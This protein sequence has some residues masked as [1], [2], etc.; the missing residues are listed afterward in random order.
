MAVG[1]IPKYIEEYPL[2]D[3]APEQFIVIAD[4][5]IKQLEWKI[6]YISNTGII[7]FTGDGFF[8]RCHEVRITIE[9]TIATLKSSSVR[10]EMIDWG[11]NKSTV[12]DFIKTFDELRQT[13]TDDELASKH[14]I[15]K[16]N[17][18]PE[19]NDLLKLP[20][21]GIAEQ[22]TG[23]LSI[24]KPA[25]GY[26]IT[27]ILVN[28]N[29]L[30]F[31]LMAIM[32][33]NI[34][35]PDN[36]SLLNW[37]ANFRPLTLDGQW[38]RLITNI[39]L[40]IGIIH[41]LLNMYALVYIGLLLEPHLGKIRFISAYLLTGL[42]A[43]I[44]SL[45]WHDITI[46]AGASGAIF[47]MYG[48]FL[49]MLTTDLIEKTT[50]K[51]LLTSIGI[52]VA[53]NLIN[54]VKGNID[55]AAHIGGL[56]GGLIIGYCFTPSLKKPDDNPL[57]YSIIGSLTV[58]TIIA[59]SL[60]YRGIPNDIGSYE[61]EMKRFSSMESMALEVYSLPKNT[62][63]SKLLY[64]IKDRGIYYWNEDLKIIDEVKKL[65]LP[66]TLQ[67]QADKLKQ[68]CELRLKSYELLYKTVDE[69]SNQY[70]SQIDDY[71]KQIQNI[72]DELKKS[73]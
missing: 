9:N 35:M 37:G 52:F 40:H 41:L 45:W 15:I 26:L 66:E 53:Y 44:A 69:D 12:K 73:K 19:E 64:E 62:P 8:S 23:F 4:E 13:F 28:L 1:F 25:K 59:C 30:V 6:S 7:A 48:V 27:P 16:E 70:Q 46:S 20:P 50:R 14:L 22:V 57:N 63:K 29:I 71:N 47:G 56:I 32:G 2:N 39:F 65:Q 34:L 17:L 54:G 3:L 55:N 36:E 68:Y 33:I 18:V 49:A 38:W 60:V 31:I 42:T 24:F 43:S 61:K 11:R 10:N 5:A 67:T 21:P 72:I 58:L 51:A